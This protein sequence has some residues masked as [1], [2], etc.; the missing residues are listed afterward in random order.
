MKLWRGLIVGALAALAASAATADASVGRIQ[1]VR[2][3]VRIDAFGKGAFIEA[4]E[5]DLLYEAS[6]IVVDR[7]GGAVIV[8]GDEE[9]RI[10]AGSTVHVGE[11]QTVRKR[12]G[13][14][15]WARSVGRFVGS[16]IRTKNEDEEEVALGSRAAQ[17]SDESDDFS[18]VEEEDEDEQRYAKARQHIEAGEFEVALETFFEIEYDE[19]DTYLPADLAFWTGLC[20]FQLGAFRE[21]EAQLSRALEEGEMLTLEEPNMPADRLLAYQLGASRYLLG[22]PDE[23]TRLLT[24]AAGEALDDEIA[25]HALLVLIPALAETGAG[26]EARKQLDRARALDLGEEYAAELADLEKRIFR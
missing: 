2:G 26:N 22:R 19:T 18:W 23:G 10:P 17:A 8:V 11:V 20:Y 16:I 15:A 14:F 1:E 6:V 7:N 12:R 13:L 25:G 9:T 21:A 4:I 24:E 3:T 5:G